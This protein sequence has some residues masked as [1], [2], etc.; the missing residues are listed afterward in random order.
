MRKAGESEPPASAKENKEMR[1]REIGTSIIPKPQ[2]RPQ[3]KH[4]CVVAVKH[5]A[6]RNRDLLPL[7]ASPGFIMEFNE[8][9][10]KVK[11]DG[12]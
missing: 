11:Q 1:Y 7:L 5:P 9:K 10:G 3:V 2:S 4:S 12:E 6:V 8:M